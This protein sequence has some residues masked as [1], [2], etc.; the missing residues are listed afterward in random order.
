MLAERNAANAAQ[1]GG[2]GW[3]WCPLSWARAASKGDMGRCPI[4]RK[5]SKRPTGA[6]FDPG[7]TNPRPSLSD[8]LLGQFPA[9]AGGIGGVAPDGD[10]CFA[11]FKSAPAT[12][13]GHSLC[14][15]P[16]VFAPWKGSIQKTEFKAR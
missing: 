16:P 3:P 10:G 6:F 9:L 7:Q 14:K 1:C 4:P 2:C 11:A 8:R 5:A 13:A 15:P 12:N